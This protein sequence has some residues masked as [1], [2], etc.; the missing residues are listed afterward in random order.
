MIRLLISND[1]GIQAPGLHR[2][3][4]TLKGLGQIWVVAPDREQS[5]VGH[6]I[7][8]S[9]P[10][11]LVP[12]TID[13]ADKTYAI[14]GTPAD[15]VKLAISALMPEPPTLVVS[16]I[17]RGE[18]TGISVIYSGTVS[19]ATEGTINGI[20]SLAVSLA[21]FTSSDY[22]YAAKVA[23]KFVREVLER[24]LPDGTLLSI[25]VPA[26]PEAEIKGIRY[27]RQ[28]RVRYQETFEKRMDPRGR[29]YYWMDGDKV[30]N[31]ERDTDDT[32]VRSGYVAVTPIAL[33][34]TNY[35]FLKQLDG[36]PRMLHEEI[37]A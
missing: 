24:G 25:N 13:G 18:N 5:S 35:E 6:S 8:L 15:C 22:H 11:R 3:V 34:L 31:D 1:D 37:T 4:K 27:V 10:I 19:A 23:E 28:G 2:L 26:L 36:W 17:N 29:V 30:L 14:S 12:W 33:D 9:D 21:S 20:P 32:A 16:G 7:T